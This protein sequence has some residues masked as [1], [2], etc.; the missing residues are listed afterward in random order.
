MKSVEALI[1]IRGCNKLNLLRAPVGEGGGG[2]ASQFCQR[3]RDP[4]LWFA[5]FGVHVLRLKPINVW[6][7]MQIFPA[8]INDTVHYAHFT[9]EVLLPSTA[10]LASPQ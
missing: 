5:G 3:T 2:G 9:F 7:W 1:V 8:E 10:Q 4:G 6:Q